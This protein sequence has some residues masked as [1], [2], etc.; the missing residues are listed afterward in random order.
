MSGRPL[1]L[2]LG[3]VALVAGLG[4]LS[5]TAAPPRDPVSGE[6]LVADAATAWRLRR[7]ALSIAT[8]RLEQVDSA[9]TFPRPHDALDLPA[10]DELWALAARAVTAGAVGAPGEVVDRERLER[11]ALALGPALGLVLLL[12]LHLFL[13]Q[14]AGAGAGALA[15]TLVGVGGP[16]ALACAA[17]GVVR[18]ELTAAVVLL[19]GLR[20]LL[21]ALGSRSPVDRFTEAMIAGALFGL[22]LAL[23]PLF[24][25]PAAAA[26]SAF[27]RAA[28][29]APAGEREDLGRAFLLFWI[30]TTLGGLLPALGGP[31]LPAAEGL[32]RGWTRLVSE[33]ALL[34]AVPFVLLRLAP[35]RVG[36]WLGGPAGALWPLALLVVSAVLL[37]LAG[38]DLARTA[39]LSASLGLDAGGPVHAPDGF[40]LAG[41]ALVALACLGLRRR[42]PGPERD[43][44]AGLALLA[45]GAALVHPPALLLA[46]APAGLG[47]AASRW[48]PR[49]AGPWLAAGTAA[50]A[51]AFGLTGAGAPSPE[52]VAV[53]RAS[54]ALRAALGPSP[55]MESPRPVQRGA[56]LCA[57]GVAPLVVWHAGRP[58]VTGGPARNG[59]PRGRREHEALLALERAAEVRAALRRERV[60]LV[61]LGPGQAEG[62]A[63]AALGEAAPAG[64]I[65]PA[66]A[67]PG[68]PRFLDLAA[69]P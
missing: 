38:P 36:R 43:L 33:L 47:V 57:P 18:I 14:V 29:R 69:L 53:A 8:P 21:A 66:G 60:G 31:W 44:L 28:A 46:A 25:I 49:A 12:G 50:L 42:E 68:E 13:R 22:G 24:L 52:A 58:C 65:T 34:G 11:L 15:G 1:A 6:R 41:V 64:A 4:A 2:L 27:L 45:V 20:V 32:V 48:A 54:R 55:G 56:V 39:V 19:A 63:P 30:T 17:P 35:E 37:G 5:A 62:A 10:H 59:D 23:S 7:V 40:E 3:L 26:L 67:G 16:V 9:L 51:L 61:L